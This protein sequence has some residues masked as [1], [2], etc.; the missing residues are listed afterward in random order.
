[1]RR[2][3]SHTINENYSRENGVFYKRRKNVNELKLLS[4]SL[5]GMLLL[6][7]RTSYNDGRRRVFW[8]ELVVTTVALPFYERVRWEKQ[9]TQKKTSWAFELLIRFSPFQWSNPLVWSLSAIIHSLN[10]SNSVWHYVRVEARRLYYSHFFEAASFLLK[11]NEN[12]L[13]LQIWTCGVFFWV[14]CIPNLFNKNPIAIV[15]W[16][17]QKNHPDPAQQTIFQRWP[18]LPFCPAAIYYARA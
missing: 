7:I 11:G 16:D 6:P 14:C 5:A 9:K 1:M 15:Q 13:K 17:T 8:K 4:S 3:L 18:L 12:G 2:R 10:Q